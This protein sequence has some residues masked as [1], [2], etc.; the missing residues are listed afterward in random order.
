MSNG[1]VWHSTDLINNTSQAE[2][3]KNKIIS[4]LNIASTFLP[5]S[6]VFLSFSILLPFSVFAGSKN[7]LYL[8][9]KRERGKKRRPRHFQQHVMQ[10]TIYQ[11]KD[12]KAIHERPNSSEAIIKNVNTAN[13]SL[14]AAKIH[15]YRPASSNCVLGGNKNKSG[16][17]FKYD[18]I[19]ADAATAAA[20]SLSIKV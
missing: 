16:K 20:V 10:R 19:L 12:G 7:S 3:E 13:C 8:N 14:V 11:P 15:S 4:I 9:R 1:F 5:S 18:D 2:N 17:E 6:L